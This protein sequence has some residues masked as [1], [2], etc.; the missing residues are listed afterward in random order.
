MAAAAAA[1]SVASAVA[2]VAA[3]VAGGGRQCA[4]HHTAAYHMAAVAACMCLEVGRDATVLAAPPLLSPVA[5]RMAA[6]MV[7]PPAAWVRPQPPHGK[8]RVDTTSPSRPKR[9]RP[10]AAQH[11]RGRS[12]SPP[13]PAVRIR[14]AHVAQAMTAGLKAAAMAAMVVAVHA[15]FAGRPKIVFAQ[16]ENRAFDHMIGALQVRRCSPWAPCAAC[17]LPPHARGTAPYAV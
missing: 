12:S 10:R 7:R 2:G 5:P 13:P 3:D 1:A 6:P 9:D 16:F 15:G 14:V 4:W 8:I 17:R 11:R